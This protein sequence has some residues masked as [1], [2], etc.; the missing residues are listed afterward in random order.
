MNTQLKRNF[1]K[2]LL[3]FALSLLGA[4]AGWVWLQ[5]PALSSL[6]HQPVAAHLTGQEHAAATWRGPDQAPVVWPKPGVQSHGAGWLYE[7]FTPPVIY[8]NAVAKTFMVTPPQYFGEGNAPLFGVELLAV[9]LE[10]YRLQLVGYFGAPGD[11]LA[12]FVTPGDAAT[13]LAREGRT[14]ADLGLTLKNFS[15]RKVLVE[16]DDPWPVYDIAAQA[17]LFDEKSGTEVVLDNRMRKLTD[18]PLAVLRLANGTAGA[19]ELH[20][21]DT[22]R[23]DSGVYRVERIQLDPPEVV[24]A[25]EIPGLPLPERKILRPMETVNPDGSLARTIPVAPP[26]PLPQPKSEFAKADGK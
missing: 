10:A 18:T 16:H 24:V 23:D 20:E 14:F 8:Y 2:L 21:G 7:V 19:R 26:K 22:L 11:Y 6:R 4:S 13:L 1:D 25:R 17:V 12:A 3:A 5:Q 15:V 9:R